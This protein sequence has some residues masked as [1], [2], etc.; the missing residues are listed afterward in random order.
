[1]VKPKAPA[2]KP[3][4]PTKPVPFKLHTTEKTKAVAAGS[5]FKPMAV[6][7]KE[8]EAKP[9]D[10]KKT[11]VSRTKDSALTQPKSPMLMTRLRSKMADGVSTKEKELKMLE[12]IAPFKAKPA[13][14]KV[15]NVS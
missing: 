3:S 4:G 9:N 12:T 2:A 8:F 13:S 7:L 5:P 15:C 6:R 14:K 10:V 1:V 11:A